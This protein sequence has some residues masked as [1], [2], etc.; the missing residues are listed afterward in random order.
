MQRGVAEKKVITQKPIMVQPNLPRFVREGDKIQMPVKVVNLTDK[1]ITGSA[2]LALMN[3][4]TN[5]SVDGWFKNIYANQYFTVAAGQSTVVLFPIEIPF[6]Y[7][8]PLTIRTSA[9]STQGTDLAVSD[10]EENIL[11]VLT[12]RMLVTETMP[13]TMK[14]NSSK[15]FEFK[16]LVQN[17]SS[18]LTHQALTVEFTSN[19]VWYAVQALPYLMEY[20]FECA[21]QTFSRYYANTL[22]THIANKTPRIKEVFE[23][24]KGDGKALQSALQRNEDLKNIVLAETPWVMEVQNEAAQ[25]Q[26]IALLF[27]LQKMAT[28]QNAALNKLKELQTSN[29]GFM[30][31]KGGRDDR[32]ITQYILTGIGHLIKLNVLDADNKDMVRLV[33]KAI[34]YTDQR[35]KE[36]YDKLKD[37]S[38]FGFPSHYELNYLYMRSFFPNIPIATN[39]TTAYNFYIKS[40]DKNWL[41]QSK[42]NQALIALVLHRNNKIA[43]AKTIVA[44]LKENAII[45]EELGMY[46]KDVRPGYYWYEAPTETMALMVELFNE[47][48][49]DVGAVLGL[50][51]WLLKNKQTTNWK[52]TKATAE[53]CYALLLQGDAWTTEHATVTLKLNNTPIAP[54]NAEPGTGYIKH[55]VVGDKVQEKMGNIAVAVSGSKSPSWGAAYWQYFENLDKITQAETPLSLKK[56]LY[57]QVI[58]KTGIKLEEV[59]DN[60]QLK[61]GDK[62][63]V[64][65]ELRV[66]REMEYVHMKDMRSAGAEPL[67]VL[68]Q[69]K[70]QDG[71][72]YYEATKDASTN[73]FFSYLYKGTYIFEYPLYVTHKGSFSNGITTIQC[74][75]APEFTSHSEG[76]KVNVE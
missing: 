75:Y 3:P 24:W 51:T 37:K 29:G 19:P 49:N 52:T 45:N 25:K 34:Q 31:F 40:V 28:E 13:L 35:M 57:K 7:N 55:Q 68:S 73:F 15:N 76:V 23:K 70:W 67:N 18:T 50:K 1:E 63:T 39:A 44:S 60:A 56:K 72:G 9:V 6:G 4:E 54:T 17:N 58:T 62:L 71:L 2:E 41:Q 5:T 14:P 42:Y 53:A 33:E 74:M 59:A 21:E 27:D 64:R 46:W 26:K 43:N 8:K 65:I 20:P 61:I 16:K 38:K 36:D 30:W 32:F 48:G 47:V 69:Y 12:N 11:P 22:A 66:D 10:A